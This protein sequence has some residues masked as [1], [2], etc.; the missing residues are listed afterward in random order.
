MWYTIHCRRI[1]F[2]ISTV[3]RKTPLF[4]LLVVSSSLITTTQLNKMVVHS[5]CCFHYYYYCI[6]FYV[7]H[8]LL[9]EVF[10]TNKLHSSQTIALHS[11]VY[12]YCE[13]NSN[14]MNYER[15][16]STPESRSPRDLTLKFFNWALSGTFDPSPVRT[17]LFSMFVITLPSTVVTQFTS[18]IQYRCSTPVPK[19]VSETSFR[20][21]AATTKGII[22]ETQ[23]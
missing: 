7:Y 10:L 1:T 23:C 3:T 20:R 19:V 21:A 12:F 11:I 18:K 8:Y 13:Q 5:Y 6:K 14:S 9:A 16:V 15:R 4:T 2:Q 17:I 22:S